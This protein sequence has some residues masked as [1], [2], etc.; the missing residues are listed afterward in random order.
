M[1]SVFGKALTSRKVSLPPYWGLVSKRYKIGNRGGSLSVDRRGCYCRWRPNIRKRFGRLYGLLGH[2]F[3]FLSTQGKIRFSVRTRSEAQNN[4]SAGQPVK[5]IYGYR[6]LVSD[7]VPQRSDDFYL[8]SQ[9]SALIT[10]T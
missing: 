10:Q 1:S 6:G 3:L 8:A 4:I 9:K 2:K 5:V 7:F